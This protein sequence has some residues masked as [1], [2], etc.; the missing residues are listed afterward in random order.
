MRRWEQSR[1]G[2]GQVV[3]LSGEAGI[4]KSSLVRALHTH[5]SQAEVTR[6][7]FR[8]SPYHTNSTLYPV[9]NLVQQVLRFAHEDAA[10]TRLAKLEQGLQ[11]YRLPLAEVV[12]LF[13][14]LLSLPLP[15]GRYP[16][17]P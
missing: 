16:S 11:R 13:T 12:P 8:C 15:D 7:A 4:G 17:L 6:F 5:V 14:A 1:A 10:E 3:L 2:L 9:I